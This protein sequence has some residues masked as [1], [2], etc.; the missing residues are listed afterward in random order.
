MDTILTGDDLI[1]YAK[2]IK[3]KKEFEYFLICLV[4]DYKQNKQEWENGDLSSYLMG[5]KE[6]VPDIA[7]YYQNNAEDF[8]V[9]K[10]TWRMMADILLAASVY[11]S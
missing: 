8:D 9:E 4:Y 1:E 6:F 11:G 5:L 3:S 2:T 7:G 10:I